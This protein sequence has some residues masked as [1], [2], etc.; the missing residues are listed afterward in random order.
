M[1]EICNNCGYA[2]ESLVQT[3]CPKCGNMQ[4]TYRREN[5]IPTTKELKTIDQ[6]TAEVLSLVERKDLSGIACPECG[7]ELEWTGTAFSLDCLPP[8]VRQTA[9][10]TACAHEVTIRRA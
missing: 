9:K 4:W 1:S 5:P 2:K 10:C 6:H 3:A 7:K 8:I